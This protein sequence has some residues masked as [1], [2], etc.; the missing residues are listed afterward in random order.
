M[1]SPSPSISVPGQFCKKLFAS[2]QDVIWEQYFRPSQLKAIAAGLK[3]SGK[4]G[5]A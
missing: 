2:A 3:L 1:P 4:T 5:A